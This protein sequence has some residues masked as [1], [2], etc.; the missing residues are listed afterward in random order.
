[1]YCQ[2]TD[3]TGK[4]IFGKMSA[5]QNEQGHRNERVWPP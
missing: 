2:T 5:Q 4:S 3:T 1:V